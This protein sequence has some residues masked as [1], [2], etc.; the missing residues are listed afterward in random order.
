MQELADARISDVARAIFAS[1]ARARQATRKMIAEDVGVSL[2]T[3]TTALAELS[4][5]RLATELRREQGARG[6]A[7]LV[8]GISPL[9]GWIMGIDIGATQITL[10]AMG[11]DGTELERQNLD[12]GGAPLQAAGLA[13]AL[14]QKAAASQGGAAPLRAVALALNQIVPR[15]L[16]GGETPTVTHAMVERF[17]TAA[18]LDATVPLLVENN[19][20]CAAVTEHQHGLMRDH[21]DAVYFQIGVGIGVGIFCDGRLIRGGHGASGELA[22]VPVS[23]SADVDSPR[24][25]IETAYGST[26]LIARLRPFWPKGLSMPGSI[27][28]LLNVALD[29]IAQARQIITEHGIALGRLAA[30]TATLLDPSILVIGGGLSRNGLITETMA[31][32]FAARTRFTRIDISR[33]GRHATADGAAIIASEYLNR[34]IADRHYRTTISNPPVWTPA[35]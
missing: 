19:V 32:E 8:Y 35:A 5:A 18:A 22:Q 27:T 25:A 6:R 7:T 29:E 1:L 16:D 15:R 17:A 23:W 21:A 4:G 14:A 11:L 9:A 33:L 10:V 12:H 24:N 34:K 20:N 28:E 2:P 31:A 13:G 3:V 30:A 26:G